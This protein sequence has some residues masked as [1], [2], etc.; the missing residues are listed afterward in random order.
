MLTALIEAALR[1]LILAMAVWAGLRIFR[2]RNVV[3]ERSAWTVV[4]IGSL[5]MPLCTAF[6]IPL[7]CLLARWNSGSQ[8]RLEPLRS[9]LAP[10]PGCAF[11][12]SSP[13]SQATSKL[14]A[15]GQLIAAVETKSAATPNTRVPPLLAPKLLVRADAAPVSNQVPD[16]GLG[17]INSSVSA[18]KSRG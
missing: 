15:P 5:L 14:F 7:A 16:R 11:S 4:L 3:S 12:N 13:S 6:H 18:R 17:Q 2:I 8:H 10:A 1:S 9:A